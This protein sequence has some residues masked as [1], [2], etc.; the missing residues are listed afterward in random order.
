MQNVHG[1]QKTAESENYIMKHKKIME[2]KV[3]EIDR[4][5]QERQ[6]SHLGEREEEKQE[7]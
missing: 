5:L 7:N 3:K 6:G 1:C 4:E 2:M